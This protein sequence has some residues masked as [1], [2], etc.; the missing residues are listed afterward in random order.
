MEHLSV[1]YVWV[2]RLGLYWGRE[3][4]GWVSVSKPMSLSVVVV[5]VTNPSTKESAAARKGLARWH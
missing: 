5:S 3:L 2:H 1:V 4:R